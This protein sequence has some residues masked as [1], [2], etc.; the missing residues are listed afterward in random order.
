MEILHF[1]NQIYLYGLGLIPFFILV[2]FAY[3]RQNKKMLYKYGDKE[4][5]MKLMPKLSVFRKRWKFS[6]LMLAF[7]FL[8]ISLAN[9]QIGSKLEKAKR[10]GVDLL[11]AVDISN[12]MMAQDIQP[13]RLERSKMAIMQ[14]IDKLQGDRIGVVVFAGKAYPQLP[15][16][17]DYA[18]AKM[19]LS[20][21]STDYINTQG[22]SLASAITLGTESFDK[23][24]DEKRKNNKAIIIITDGEDHE[25]GAIEAAKLAKEDGIR[26]YTI[27]MGLPEGAPIPLYR[28]GTLIGYKK[29]QQGLT[30]MT[31]LNEPM[32]QNVAATG[33]GSY[34]RANNTKVGLD[35]IFEDINSLQKNEIEVNSFKDYEDR[36]QIFIAFV[37]FILLLEFFIPEKKSV[38]LENLNLFGTK[39]I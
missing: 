10:L 17:T 23:K 9:P 4:L 36:F 35:K 34:V 3:N 25:E 15:I 29:D 5:I 24:K 32:L 14:L 7:A 31:K 12:S 2:F 16:T 13:N 37:L 19:F 26:I 33:G 27:G 8:C 20:S 39:K 18:S 6:L 28:N 30:I 1:E 21:V 38:F 11:I 22:T